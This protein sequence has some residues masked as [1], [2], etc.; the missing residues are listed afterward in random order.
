[1]REIR[2]KLASYVEDG[3]IL[4]I[5]K[6]NL[7]RLP[8]G[9]GGIEGLPEDASVR[10]QE[11]GLGRLVVLSPRFGVV[12][13]DGGAG[14]APSAALAGLGSGIDRPLP[15]PYTLPAGIASVIDRILLSQMLF[16]TSDGLSL[17][18]CRKGPGEYT[19][20]IANNGWRERDLRITSR[21]GPIE[22]IRE[23]PLDRSEWG[24]EGHLPEGVDGSAL[25]KSTQTSIAGGDVRIFAVRVEEN[26]VEEIAGTDPPPRPRGRFLPLRRIGSLE[27]EILARPTFFQHF[28][29]AVVDWRYL[30][31]RDAAALEV[32]ARWLRRQGLRIAADLSSGIDLF[33]TLRL[34]DN[35]AGD[36]AASLAAIEGVMAKM[37]ILGARDLILSLHRHPENNF[38]GEQTRAAFEKT[39]AS[40]AARAAGRGIALHLRMA[41]GKPPWSLAEAAQLL[42]RIGA[43]NLKL[44]PS[45]ALLSASG[46]P[47]AEIEKL[48]AGRVGL[49][50]VS[51][52]RRDIAGRLWDAHARIH[53]APDADALV[54]PISLAPDAPL[55]LDAVLGTRDEEYLEAAALDR[56]VPRRR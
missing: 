48:L 35:I 16:E 23:L 47:R 39:L 51:A 15:R 2:D 5:A 22:S 9:I 36:Y 54:R 28:D 10:E 18:T 12:L 6:G 1:G 43:P 38:T 40:L 4:V 42:D 17:T 53:D 13:D 37:E 21:C 3:G 29:G 52:P 32:E 50:L 14:A 56:L 46:T 11:I 55:A 26:G 41:F 27:E 20:G 7:E 34:I 45:L 25:G 19:L 33:P 8:G 49:W 44:A 31:D 30:R 24:S